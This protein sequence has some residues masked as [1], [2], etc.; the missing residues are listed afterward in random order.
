MQHLLRPTRKDSKKGEKGLKQKDSASA[1]KKNF[2]EGTFRPST[3]R[4][5]EETLGKKAARF[6]KGRGDCV[7]LESVVLARKKK[8]RCREKGGNMG[9]KDENEKSIRRGGGGG[10]EERRCLSLNG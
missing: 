10:P 5:E 9:R 3:G 8:G 4:Q 2:H 7:L 6:R 1:E